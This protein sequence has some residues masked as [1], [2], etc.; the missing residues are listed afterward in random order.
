METLY[1][2]LRDTRTEQSDRA[3]KIKEAARILREGGVV[4]LPTETVYGLGANALNENAVRRIFEAKGRPQDNPLILHLSG[5]QWLPRYC[6]EIPP[7]AF[8]LTR[9][10]WPGPLT[11]VLKRRP[12]VPD[13]TAAGLDTVAVRCPNHPV[14]LALIRE[15]G[16]PIAAPSANVSGRPSC[17]T[18]QEVMDDMR[19]K[20]H[21]V[22]DGGPCQIGVESTILDLT[23]PQPRLLRPGGV[24][25]EAIETLVGPIAVDKAVTGPIG[26]GEYPKAP[27]MKYRHYAPRVPLT[28]FSGAPDATAREMSKRMCPRTGI[29]CFDGY[30]RFFPNQETHSLGP[31][32]NP[33][34]Q[35]RRLFNVLRAFDGG[36][37]T[38]IYAQCPD[39][40]GLG[41]AVGNRL[42]RAAG[43]HVVESDAQRIVIGL[44]GGT[45]AGK[46]TVL[47]VVEELGGSVL[48][49]DREYHQ[50]LET[51]ENLKEDLRRAFRD[52]FTLDGELDRKKLGA[53]VFAHKDRMA[54][55]NRIV[56]RHLYPVIERKLSSVEDGLC[57]VDAI[58]LMESGLDRLCDTT[59]AVTAPIEARVRRIMSRDGIAEEYAR[60]RI[61]AQ[62]SDEYYRTKCDYE[63]NNAGESSEAFLRETRVFLRRL[64]ENLQE[65]KRYGALGKKIDMKQEILNKKF[66]I[67][68]R[69]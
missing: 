63:L 22:L 33:G 48:D 5:P 14:A 53:E 54:K 16:Y 38:E 27:G 6:A 42:K 41:L 62:K 61:S 15:L 4:A 18:A 20:I 3:V 56:Y 57:A 64:I 34:E 49:C 19:G 37:C 69:M 29:I 13:I 1:F 43:F 39:S 47:K 24:S 25:V 59:I 28:V 52:A 45:G 58:N 8:I 23:G 30:E 44:T 26:E 21:G 66:S 17:T 60:L 10:F 55:L 65:E 35:A 12:V 2:D 68:E 36:T 31:Y 67:R 9:K 32:D 11:L 51:D 7:L 50:L 40:R 46:S